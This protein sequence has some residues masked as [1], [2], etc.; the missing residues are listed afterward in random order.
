MELPPHDLT[1]WRSY[2]LTLV[3]TYLRGLG[4]TYQCITKWT[5]LRFEFGLIK[6]YFWTVIE[7]DRDN[8]I[9]SKGKS[10][11][12]RIKFQKLCSNKSKACRGGKSKYYC[13]F[14]R[15]RR[16]SLFSAGHGE[17]SKKTR[18]SRHSEKSHSSCTL[19][20]KFL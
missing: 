8:S 4:W 6:V 9:L 5:Y 2:F 15:R 17:K 20:L 14:T 1:P 19:P 12:K 7:R 3:W 11:I 10:K 16:S 13:F 18:K